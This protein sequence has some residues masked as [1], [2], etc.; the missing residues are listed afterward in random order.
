M[1]FSVSLSTNAVYLSSDYSRI[2]YSKLL[3]KALVVLILTLT[4][5]TSLAS[6]SSLANAHTSR[7]K[8]S[9]YITSELVVP[10]TRLQ[11]HF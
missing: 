1:I 7:L 9:Q 10:A 11:E 2:L 5:P 8:T 4:T 6:F 3:T